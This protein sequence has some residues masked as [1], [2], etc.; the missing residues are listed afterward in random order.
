MT[1]NGPKSDR[2]LGAKED[3]RGRESLTTG[4][5]TQKDKAMS[6]NEDETIGD[7]NRTL[8]WER[9]L[10]SVLLKKPLGWAHTADQN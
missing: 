3:Y 7:A 1:G 8:G 10:F 2:M 9:V 6:D 5:R 4:T